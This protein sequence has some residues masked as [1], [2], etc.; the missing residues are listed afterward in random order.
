LIIALL[1][2]GATGIFSTFIQAYAVSRAH[3]VGYVKG[4]VSVVIGIII[5]G[6][7]GLLLGISVVSSFSALSGR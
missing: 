2:A 4:C 1:V 5:L 7:I 3:R 6:I